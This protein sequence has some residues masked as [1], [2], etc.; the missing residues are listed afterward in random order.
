MGRVRSICDDGAAE[1]SLVDIGH[2]TGRIALQLLQEDAV[3]RDLAER[4][5]VGRAGDAE[6]DR[7]AGAMARKPDDADIVAEILAAELGTDPERLRQPVDLRFH[8]DIAKRL[9]QLGS[10]GR[11]RVEIARRGELDRFQSQFGRC[12]AD[13]DRQVIGGTGGGP[14][15]EDLFPQEGQ[16]PIVRKDRRR[17]LVEES[18]VGRA[19]ALGNEEEF[20]GVLALGHDVDLGRQVRP[21]VA[22]LEHREGRQLRVAQVARLVGVQDAPGDSAFVLAISPDATALFCHHDGRAGILAHRQHAPGRDVGI[23]QKVVGD[24][25]VIV[26][27]L[28][29]VEDRGELGEMRRAQQVVDVAERLFR[30]TSQGLALDHQPAAYVLC[31]K[32]IS[33]ASGLS[34]S[35]IAA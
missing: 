26:R 21:G 23:L 3:T 27:R 14:E 31:R 25:A 19:A 17:R 33:A 7:Q 22:L 6:T 18:L 32:S 28:R 34:A 35:R 30:Q 29:I 4:L 11:Q 1:A 12:P 24:E 5:A 15:G 2:E 16:K 8:R 13:D 20:V 9:A 10:P